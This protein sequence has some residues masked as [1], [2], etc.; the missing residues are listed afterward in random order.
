M[1]AAKGVA[2]D[3]KASKLAD[4]FETVRQ[5]EA[6]EDFAVRALEMGGARSE[7]QSRLYHAGQ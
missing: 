2:V 1:P 4:D 5:M 7:L 3:R 6:G